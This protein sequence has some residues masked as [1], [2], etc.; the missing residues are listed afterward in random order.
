MEYM[1]VSVCFRFSS[2]FFLRFLSVTIIVNTASKLTKMYSKTRGE[3]LWR[4]SGSS[5]VGTIL[6]HFFWQ[7]L[8]DFEDQIFFLQETNDPVTSFEKVT[9]K[10]PPFHFGKKDAVKKQPGCPRTS[11]TTDEFPTPLLH[12]R[13]L[14][15]T[16]TPQ[17]ITNIAQYYKHT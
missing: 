4:P 16:P 7:I 15:P 1:V 17:T 6:F 10:S 2:G 9:V 14:V 13:W 11:A 3:Q 5:C 8:T 12:E